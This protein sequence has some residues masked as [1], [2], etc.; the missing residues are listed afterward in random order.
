MWLEQKVAHKLL[1]EFVTDVE[2]SLEKRQD[3]LHAHAQ[4]AAIRGE[5]TDSEKPYM[6]ELV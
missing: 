1:V 3:N 2:L 5:K 6:A 4:N